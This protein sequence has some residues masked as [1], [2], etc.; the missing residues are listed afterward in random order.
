MESSQR[1]TSSSTWT[2]QNPCSKR[3]TAAY[4]DDVPGTL[5]PLRKSADQGNIPAPGVFYG[6]RAAEARKLSHPNGRPMSVEDTDLL[7]YVDGRI[8]PEGRAR[9][10]AAVASSPGVARRLAAMRASALP[11][12]EAFERQ[13]VPPVPSHLAEH[14]SDLLRVSAVAPTRAARGRPR[15]WWGAAAAAVATL[16]VCGGAL[17]VWM[18]KSAASPWVEAVASYQELYAR[19]TLSSITADQALTQRVLSDSRNA[20]VTVSIPDLSSNGLEFKRVQRLSFRGQP[21]IQIVYLPQAGDPVALCIMRESS[22]RGTLHLQQLG[23]MKA[24]VW[25]DGALGYV[26]IAKN[27]PVDLMDLGRRISSGAIPNLFTATV[28]A[29]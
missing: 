9:V 6:Y 15:V 23:P 4:P 12:A 28:D 2:I 7:A 10:D 18:D 16:V 24:A 17:K 11:Y 8:S 3:G 27:T 5:S 19:E 22:A 1:R 20:G 14:L 21:V 13:A 29:G 26:L 25:H